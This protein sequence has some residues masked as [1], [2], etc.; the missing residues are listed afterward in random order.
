VTFY[1]R[2][3][4]HLQRDDKPHFVTFVT[5]NRAVLPSWAR[6]I[7]LGCC[8]HDHETRYKLHVAVVM[9]DHVHLILTP[10]MDFDRAL[11]LPLPKIMQAIKSAC[12]HLI[13]GRTGSH[14]AIW[15]EESFDRVLR[16]SEKLDEK[17]ALHLEQSSAKRDRSRLA[18][19]QMGL[20]SG[21]AKCL[22]STGPCVTTN[23]VGPDAP[24][25]AGER[26]SPGCARKT[27]GPCPARAGEGARPYVVRSEGAMPSCWR[28]AEFARPL[29]SMLRSRGTWVMENFRDRVNLRQIQCKE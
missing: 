6:D 29:A 17:I 8:L 12:A 16:C 19:V 14:G 24:V 4:P 7:V 27:A 5:K 26:S 2:N 11:V 20:V 18:E 15:Q 9:P 13:N 23:H 21:A 25:R 1:R 22:C 28:T 3:L 10:L